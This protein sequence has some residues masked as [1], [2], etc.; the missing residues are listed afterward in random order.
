MPGYGTRQNTKQAIGKEEEMYKSKGIWYWYHIL[1]FGS[2]V[3]AVASLYS[4]FAL[5]NSTLGLFLVGWAILIKMEAE[6]LQNELMAAGVV[7][8][9]DGTPVKL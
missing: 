9:K 2:V 8:F 6:A 1:M 5:E 7:G 4:F 3:L